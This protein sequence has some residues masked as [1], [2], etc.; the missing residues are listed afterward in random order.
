M[1]KAKLVDEF[2]RV[3]IRPLACDVRREIAETLDISYFT[4][5]GKLSKTVGANFTPSQRQKLK[6]YF[7]ERNGKVSEGTGTPPA[8]E[9]EGGPVLSGERSTEPNP[10]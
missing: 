2:Y 8:D 10:G 4:L 7:H 1:N 3:K 6:E 9:P 5:M